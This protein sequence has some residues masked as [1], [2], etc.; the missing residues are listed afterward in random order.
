MRRRG[1]DDRKGRASDRPCIIGDGV[2]RP[3]ALLGDAGEAEAGVEF[4]R[5]RIVRVC[6]HFCAEP[7]AAFGNLEGGF[8]QALAEALPAR[9]P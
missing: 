3:V 8:I 6:V 7:L 5:S 2:V 4:V 1:G 9:G